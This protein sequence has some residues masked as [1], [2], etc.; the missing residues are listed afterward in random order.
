M[1]RVLKTNLFSIY[2]N[3]IEGEVYV[4]FNDSISRSSY[5]V[6]DTKGLIVEKNNCLE[7]RN[8]IS[9]KNYQ[10]GMYI[11]KVKSKDEVF[12]KN[13]LKL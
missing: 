11:V 4:D 6:L 5:E 10:K 3:P 1:I 2:Q 8:T 7:V 9:L 12:V 13:F